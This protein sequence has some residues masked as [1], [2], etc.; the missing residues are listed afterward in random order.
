MKCLKHWK[1]F[2]KAFLE[3]LRR[4]EVV[5]MMIAMDPLRQSQETR[6]KLTKTHKKLARNSLETHKKHARNSQE[7]MS[8]QNLIIF[9]NFQ[10]WPIFVVSNSKKI[11]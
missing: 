3:K 6:K 7:T 8:T 5:K 4:A 10:Y 9:R 1:G 11:P 2:K